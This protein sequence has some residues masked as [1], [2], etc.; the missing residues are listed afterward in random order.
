MSLSILLVFVGNCFWAAANIC[1]YIADLLIV[2]GEP[3]P[4]TLVKV[5]GII[6]AVLAVTGRLRTVL[7][8]LHHFL[9]WWRH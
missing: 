7:H 4:G 2:Y 1:Y 3:G 5:F 8:E 9:L 6:S